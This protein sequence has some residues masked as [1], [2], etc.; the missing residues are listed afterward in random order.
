LLGFVESI[1]VCLDWIG[2]D[3]MGV[4]ISISCFR[5]QLHPAIEQ[6]GV[7]EVVDRPFC[8]SFCECPGRL[9]RGEDSSLG[10][11]EVCDNAF[12][13]RT[14]SVFDGPYWISA[15]LRTEG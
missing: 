5:T 11:L 1:G 12:A 9:G 3:C 6:P 7:V 8:S 4:G 2:S 15:P 13:I 14:W 10:L